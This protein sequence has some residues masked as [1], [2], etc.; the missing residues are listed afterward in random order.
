MKKIIL[1]AGFCIAS[2]GLATSSFAKLAAPSEEAKL[3]AA[4]AKAKTA[5]S[6]KVGAYQLCKAQDKVAAGYLKAK[7]SAAPTPLATPAC[8]D[9]G[10]YV[11][12]PAGPAPLAAATP[13]SA[14]VATSPAASAPKK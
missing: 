4:E 6:D 5:W 9:P 3:K 2:L 1:I 14:V 8:A 13:A 10:P 7:G 11:A 12:A